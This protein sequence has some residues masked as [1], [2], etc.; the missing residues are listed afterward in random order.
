MERQS[1]H[2]GVTWGSNGKWIARCFY[3]APD[4]KRLYIGHFMPYDR[5]RAI[6]AV[7]RRITPRKEC[8]DD[9]R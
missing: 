6:A 4:G 9:E 8:N 3:D 7:E 1:G 2:P 5:D